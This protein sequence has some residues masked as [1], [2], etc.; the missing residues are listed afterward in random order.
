MM[1]YPRLKAKRV[2]RG[3]T[4]SDV[5]NALG[6]CLATYC[7]KEKGKYDFTLNEILKLVKVL[8]CKFED[9]FLEQ[10]LPKQ[11]TGGLKVNTYI[12]A[13]ELQQEL[14]ISY[15]SALEIIKEVRKEMEKHGYLLPKGKELI[16]IKKLVY[17][18]L[19]IEG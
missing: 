10:L 15:Q 9:I 7:H 16:A 17:K 4:Q 19:G 18:R 1:K 14:S 2:E 5:A 12:S 8:D 6:M 11:V 3:Y 13:K